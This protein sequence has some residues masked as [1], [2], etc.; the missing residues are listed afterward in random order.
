MTRCILLLVFCVLASDASAQEA[1]RRWEM[2]RQIRLDKFEQVLPRAM[3]DNGIDMWI[4]AVKENHYDPLWKD[5]GRGYVTGVG[6]YMFTDRGGDRIERIALGPTGYLINESGAYDGMSANTMLA[7]FVKQ[8]DPKR[9]GVNMSDEIGPADGLSA[10]MLAQLKKTLG[11]PYATRLVSAEKLVSEFRSR[12]V[13]S[14]IVAFG[15]AAGIAVQLAE[16]ALSNEVITVGKTTLEDVAWWL[17]DRLLERG[18]G[19]EFDMPSIYVTGPTGIVATSTNRIIQPGDVMMIDWGVQLMNFGTDVKRVAYVLKP[20][21]TAPPK[22]IQAAFD[23]AL[24]VRDVLKKAIKPGL[25]A[26]QTMKNMDAALAAAGFGVIEFNR[27]N[28]DDRTDVVYGFHPVGNTG[29]DIGPSM[30]TWQPIQRTFVLRTQHLFSFEYF[31]YTP[32]AEWDG[33]KLR[34]PI[35]DDALLTEDGI[36]FVHPANYRLLIVK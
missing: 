28:R 12:R 10:T 19:S 7:D 4:V 20:G 36:Q 9:I 5:L 3:R 13:A 16:R 29:H 18:L 33:A 21:E 14:E 15:E 32:I 11:E 25:T 8:R 23:K 1:R 2:E 17:Q 24:S 31:A 35:E 27:P 6:Y 26:D 30:T 22:S 34:I